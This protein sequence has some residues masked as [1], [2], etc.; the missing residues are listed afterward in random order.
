MTSVIRRDTTVI[1]SPYNYF[2]HIAEICIIIIKVFE[3]I[4][5]V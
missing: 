1:T 3:K 5:K 4:N 2:F